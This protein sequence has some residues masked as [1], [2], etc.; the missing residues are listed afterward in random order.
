MEAGSLVVYRMTGFMLGAEGMG[1]WVLPPF[2]LGFYTRTEGAR[3][4][5]AARLPA[6]A[7]D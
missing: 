4:F 5:R 2:G 7:N 6:E 1:E 3:G